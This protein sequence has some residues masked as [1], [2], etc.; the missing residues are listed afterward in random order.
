MWQRIK[1]FFQDLDLNNQVI[2]SNGVDLDLTIDL[3]RYRDPA[4]TEGQIVSAL[5]HDLAQRAPEQ[6]RLE[7]LELATILA[8]GICQARKADTPGTKQQ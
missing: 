4:L 7:R 8:Q 1:S 5:E 3:D 2:A 6:S